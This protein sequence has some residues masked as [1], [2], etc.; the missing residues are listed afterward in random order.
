[1]D[2]VETLGTYSVEQGK[3]LINFFMPV[4]DQS[5]FAH[6]LSTKYSLLTQGFIPYG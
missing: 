2:I 4:P 1:M 6:Q 5:L 3:K